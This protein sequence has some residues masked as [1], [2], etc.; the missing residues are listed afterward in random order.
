VGL[1][2]EQQ[3]LLLQQQQQY[4]NY[5]Q[6]QQYQQQQQTIVHQTNSVSLS[7]ASISVANIFSGINN[8]TFTARVSPVPRSMVF[9]FPNLQANLF[10]SGTCQQTADLNIW[11]CIINY[12]NQPISTAYTVILTASADIG[13][14]STQFTVNPVRSN[15]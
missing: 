13:N 9:N 14:W 15:M 1:T 6:Q 12:K 2:Y 5:L 11:N 3:Q 4:Q 10:P 8:A 7:S